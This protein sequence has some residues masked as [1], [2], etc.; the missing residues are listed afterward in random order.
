M[1]EREWK[2]P[3]LPDDPV[4]RLVAMGFGNREQNRQ[5]LE[6]HNYQLQ[7]HTYICT[8]LL[9]AVYI[10][11]VVSVTS[12]CRLKLYMFAFVHSSIVS[13]CFLPYSRT[14]G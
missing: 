10:L 9:F 4:E 13:C 12:V 7:V 6:K 3:D 11:A 8:T 1:M 5:L 2:A 14:S